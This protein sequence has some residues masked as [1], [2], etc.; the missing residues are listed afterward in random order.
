MK[1]YIKPNTEKAVTG[2]GSEWNNIDDWGM[3]SQ[4]GPEQVTKDA[5]EWAPEQDVDTD[6]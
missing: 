2:A 1:K 5:G 4:Q 3:N 6:W